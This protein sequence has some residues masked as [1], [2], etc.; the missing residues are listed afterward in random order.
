M[1]WIVIKTLRVRFTYE[2]KGILEVR[3]DTLATGKIRG[4][5]VNDGMF[6]EEKQEKVKGA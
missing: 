6:Q 3:A 4:L 1:P 5:M 2:I